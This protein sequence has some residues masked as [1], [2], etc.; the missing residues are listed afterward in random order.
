MD[1][2]SSP[3]NIVSSEFV[4]PHSVDVSIDI[5]SSSSH[6]HSISDTPNS[7]DSVSPHPLP[8]KSTRVRRPP[9]YLQQYHC[10]LASTSPE[11]VSKVFS[12][13]ISGISFPLSSYVSYNNLS[14]SFKHFCFSISSDVEPQYYH[15]AVKHDHWRP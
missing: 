13:G 9:E 2:P 11:F 10:Q 8:R 12:S 14:S 1:S 7:S 6:S 3:S 5:S 4:S 15:Q